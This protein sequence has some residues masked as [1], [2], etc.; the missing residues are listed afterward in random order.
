[1]EIEII[2]NIILDYCEGNEHLE[3]SKSQ[4][5]DMI[6]KIKQAILNELDDAE[7]LDDARNYVKDY[8]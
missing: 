4:L 6:H 1:M 2:K 3:F 7:H 8:L 5:P